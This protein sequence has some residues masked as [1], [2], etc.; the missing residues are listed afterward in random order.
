MGIGKFECFPSQIFPVHET[1]NCHQV[2][3][4]EEKRRHSWETWFFDRWP[5]QW[6]VNSYFYR[7]NGR[8]NYIWYKW[9]YWEGTSNRLMYQWYDFA[10]KLGFGATNMFFKISELVVES[11]PGIVWWF[12]ASVC[13]KNDE[14]FES[15]L[16][17]IF[18]SLIWVKLRYPPGN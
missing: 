4:E 3:A 13:L 8:G 12:L 11:P 18:A 5:N 14:Q 7:K 15:F 16:G 10:L 9:I 6:C 1:W 17:S 2:P